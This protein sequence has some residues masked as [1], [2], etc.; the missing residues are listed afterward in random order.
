MSLDPRI[1]RLATGQNFAAFTTLM[2]DGQPQTHVMWIDADEQ[3]LLINTETHRAKFRN[4][5][6][7]PRVTVTIWDREDP[8]RFAEVRGRVVAHEAGALARAHIDACAQ[9]YF[10]RD[11]PADQIASERV[12]LRILPERVH[13][14]GIGADGDA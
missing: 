2:P 13:F 6:R 5:M 3:H 12:L 7:D 10:G 9:R 14:N 8:Y 11:Y 4:V 1:R